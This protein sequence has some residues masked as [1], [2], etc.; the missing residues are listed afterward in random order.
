MIDYVNQYAHHDLSW[1][2]PTFLD[3]EY[4]CLYGKQDEI[5][6]W[7]EHL[8]DTDTGYNFQ[9]GHLME[10]PLPGKRNQTG[11]PCFRGP[12]IQNTLDSLSIQ[13]GKLTFS[14]TI[15]YKYIYICIKSS[16][17]LRHYV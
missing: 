12:D 1:N 6:A 3:R 4:D 13:G 16:I 15:L 14:H 7:L 2:F 10:C 5:E 8:I 11:A 17:L 9:D